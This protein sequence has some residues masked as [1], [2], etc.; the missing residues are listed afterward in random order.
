MF[1]AIK[2]TDKCVTV[3]SISCVLD[4]ELNTLPYNE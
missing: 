2:S 4:Q 1:M 3:Y